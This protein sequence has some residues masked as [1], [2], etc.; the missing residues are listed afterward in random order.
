MSDK[1]EA[2]LRATMSAARKEL[3]AIRDKRKEESNK[4]LLGKCFKFHNS[5]GAG[6]PRWWLYT[7]VTKTSTSLGVFRFQTDCYGDIRIED[8]S[9]WSGPGAYTPISREEFDEAWAK[10]L[11]KINSIKV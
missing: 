8:K 4:P 6:E 1:R 2:E 10:L 11:D 7:I 3:N 5:F 9:W